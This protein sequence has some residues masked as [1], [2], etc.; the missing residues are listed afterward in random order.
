MKDFGRVAGLVRRADILGRGEG[1]L[2]YSTKSEYLSALKLLDD[3][4]FKNRYDKVYVR[5]R[6][7]L[8][9][10]DRD[11]SRDRSYSKSRSRSRSRDRRDRSGSRS[12][13][14]S[15][16]VD[17]EDRDRDRDRDRD[18]ENDGNKKVE[19]PDKE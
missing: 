6:G 2:E 9:T 13:S 15:R 18:D 5:A 7:L 3:V 16:S 4:E 14:R 19:D 10:R 11:R 1:I 12:R 17:K 8:D